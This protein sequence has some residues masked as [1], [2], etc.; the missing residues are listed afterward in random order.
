MIA[1]VL[2]LVKGAV[3]KEMFRKVYWYEK[4]LTGV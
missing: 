4:K 1:G 2:F 3:Q